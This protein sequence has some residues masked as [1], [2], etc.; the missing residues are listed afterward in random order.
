MEKRLI[1]KETLA[2]IVGDLAETMRVYAP[3]Q[4]EDQVLFRVLEK[5]EKPLFDLRIHEMR[6]KISSFPGPRR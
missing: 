1:K 5:G 4:A 3:M 6:R 2:G